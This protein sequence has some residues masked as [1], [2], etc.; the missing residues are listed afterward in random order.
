[1]I[2]PVPGEFMQK[3][4]NPRY[5]AMRQ[6]RLGRQELSPLYVGDIVTLDLREDA[7]T[8]LIMRDGFLEGEHRNMIPIDL[9]Y[10]YRVLGN[11]HMKKLSDTYSITLRTW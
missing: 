9:A 10:N 11:R 8:F 5:V 2:Y 7:E 1:M 3:F 4:E 6:F